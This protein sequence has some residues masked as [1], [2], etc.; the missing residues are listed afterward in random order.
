MRMAAGAQVVA[1]SA[2]GTAQNLLAA[3]KAKAKA[4]ASKSQ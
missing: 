3:F 4:P 2:A 1:Q